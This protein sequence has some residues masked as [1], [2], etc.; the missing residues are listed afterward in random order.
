M[1]LGFSWGGT[2][3]RRFVATWTRR[4][5]LPSGNEVDAETMTWPHAVITG[6]TATL[7]T[8]LRGILVLLCSFNVRPGDILKIVKPSHR[9]QENG[10]YVRWDD[11]L[12]GIE[13]RI[14]LEL[15]RLWCIELRRLQGSVRHRVACIMCISDAQPQIFSCAS[16]GPL[17]SLT[18]EFIFGSRGTSMFTRIPHR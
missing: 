10:A 3:N 17:V 13:P 14:E 18:S 12:H 6:P 4:A 1:G 5:K 15:S 7:W 11:R 8:R 9:Q 2:E 16:H